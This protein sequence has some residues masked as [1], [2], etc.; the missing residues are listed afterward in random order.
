MYPKHARYQAAP[1]PEPGRN[2]VR[3]DGA[4]ASLDRQRDRVR[5]RCRRCAA[6]TLSPTR[7][8]SR[9]AVPAATSSVAR[10]GPPLSITARLCGHGVLG[11][12]ADRAV[13]VDEHHVERADGVLHPHLAVARRA[14]VEQHAAIG[15]HGA[16]GTSGRWSCCSGVIAISTLKTCCLPSWVTMTSF[17]LGSSGCGPV[18][19]SARRASGAAASGEQRRRAGSR[20][21]ASGGHAASGLLQRECRRGARISSRT[22]PSRGASRRVVNQC[23]GGLRPAARL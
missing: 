11:D 17:S 10:T 16:G 3:P 13:G 22:G 14:P 23:S 4:G 20:R 8:S 21:R 1:R 9:S 19:G 18:C 7:M 2:L 12:V 5:R 6:C 15:G